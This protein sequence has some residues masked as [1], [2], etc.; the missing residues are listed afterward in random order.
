MNEEDVEI[1]Y[2]VKKVEIHLTKKQRPMKP[3]EAIFLM[4]LGINADDAEDFTRDDYETMMEG[5]CHYLG[6]NIERMS[7][8]PAD[9]DFIE[10][11]KKDFQVIQ[12]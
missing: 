3:L 6:S 10:K 5:D 1:G 8:I 2:F 9:Q 7:K 12:N 4:L 11:L